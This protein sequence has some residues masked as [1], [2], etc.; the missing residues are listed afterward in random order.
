VNS[1]PIPIP[2]PVNIS[3]VCFID[4][5]FPS[6][7]DSSDGLHLSGSQ[8]RSKFKFHAHANRNKQ[9]KGPAWMDIDSDA[10]L[11]SS[12]ESEYL[13]TPQEEFERFKQNKRPKFA[14]PQ[15][16]RRREN[17][18]AGSPPHKRPKP[19]PKPRPRPK[20]RKPTPLPVFEALTLAHLS[21]A[22][23]VERL[24]TRYPHPHPNNRTWTLDRL[25]E[26]SVLK[27]ATQCRKLG[28]VRRITEQ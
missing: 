6:M 9:G 14:Y 19:T 26:L 1:I 25:S 3:P 17:T 15:S 20:P 7:N 27:P 13:P 16:E 22:E 5:R 11:M 21:F 10:P 23:F 28:L 4:K 12:A 8:E 2:C 24:L 18:A